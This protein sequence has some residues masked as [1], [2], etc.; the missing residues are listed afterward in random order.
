MLLALLTLF[1]LS[2]AGRRG[3]SCDDMTDTRTDELI[4][5][6]TAGDTPLYCRLKAHKRFPHWTKDC[7]DATAAPTVATTTAVATTTVPPT[8]MTTT[9]PP[10]RAVSEDTPVEETPVVV[11]SADTEEEEEPGIRRLLRRGRGGRHGR[12]NR[13]RTQ[14]TVEGGDFYAFQNKGGCRDDDSFTCYDDLL[15]T[16]CAYTVIS[17]S[18]SG[19]TVTLTFTSREDETGVAET[20]DLVCPFEGK[21]KGEN[22]DED[23]I[24]CT[25]EDYTY[26]GRTRHFSLQCSTVEH[27]WDDADTNVCPS[28]PRL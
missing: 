3:N 23:T 15:A 7:P 17:S 4:S 21:I 28:V 16:D 14:F 11:F 22:C 25:H 24:E 1:T 12:W 9:P 13:A 2:N 5:Y 8:P 27:P 10:T 19:N 20:I 18:T 26:D 6:F